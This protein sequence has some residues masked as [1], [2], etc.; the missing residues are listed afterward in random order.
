MTPRRLVLL[1]V[2]L[3]T[4]AR[5]GCSSSTETSS[6]SSS[7]TPKV[8]G[9]RLDVAKSDLKAAGVADD[10]IEVVGG[11]TFGVV[12]ESNWVVC[13]QRPAPG[14]PMTKEPRVVVDRTCPSGVPAAAPIAAA[15]PSTTTAPP[16]EAAASATSGGDMPNV[17]CMN[18]QDAQDEIQ[19]HGVFFSRS[20]DASGLD[21]SQIIDSNWVVVGQS[22]AAG[23]HIDEGDAVL[24]VVKYGEPNPC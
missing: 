11:G 19:R 10:S 7:F 18:L 1:S 17:Y 23:A 22:P 12:D 14:Q 5:R 9:E 13:E 16:V 8:V 21:R 24:E 2:A 3:S 6:T 4:A 15:A 20:H